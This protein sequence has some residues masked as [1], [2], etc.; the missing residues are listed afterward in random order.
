MLRSLPALLLACLVPG[1]CTAA[2]QGTLPSRRFLRTLAGIFATGAILTPALATASFDVSTPLDPENLPGMVL[3]VRNGGGCTGVAIASN[4]VLTTRNGCACAQNGPCPSDDDIVEVV[5]RDDPHVPGQHRQRVRGDVF[6][7]PDYSSSFFDNYWEHNL[8]IIKLRDGISP[9]HA[10]PL[11][12][13]PGYLA[14]GATA[15]LVGRFL[16]SGPSDFFYGMTPVDTYEEDREVIGLA[17]WPDC[18]GKNGGSGEAILNEAGDRLFGIASRRDCT[19]FCGED[20]LV[21]YGNTTGGNFEWIKS[22]MCLSSPWSTCDGD[23]YFCNCTANTDILWRNTNGDLAI[24]FMDG[25]TITAQTYPG[26]VA[27]EW[28]IAATGDFDA[29]G[30]SDILWRNANGQLAIW[31]LV[32][33]VNAGQLYPG[34]VGAE[35]QIQGTGDFDGD[36]HSDILWRHTNGQL[37]IWFQGD[38]EQATYPGYNNQPGPVDPAWKVIGVG[39]FNGDTYSDILWR[40]QDGRVTIWFMAGDQYL[41]EGEE[42]SLSNEFVLQAIGDFDGNRRSDLLWRN[43]TNGRLLTWFDGN[44]V[45][46]GDGYPTYG[47]LPPSDFALAMWEVQGASDFDH[48]GRDDILWRHHDGT[49]AI[50]LLDGIRFVGDLYPPAADTSWEIEALLSPAPESKLKVTQVPE[51][52][53]TASLLAGA[54][55]LAVLSQRRRAVGPSERQGRSPAPR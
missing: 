24:W 35:W 44:A 8:A 46:G 12:I 43:A 33:G 47:N 50:W 34:I 21:T 2:P 4:L 51:P 16:C 54:A 25:A 9:A 1:P 5:F 31:L 38:A 11:V 17:R 49:L 45:S 13:S 26:T 30:Q 48:D 18:E 22:H 20:D 7:H 41:G 53:G 27:E 15:L 39:D 10:T 23:G 29:N 28:Q 37:A 40:H 52:G 3:V 19:G 36:R 32:D 6:P 55:V 42:K 14:E